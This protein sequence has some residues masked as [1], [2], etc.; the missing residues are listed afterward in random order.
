MSDDTSQQP[1]MQERLKVGATVAI[2][3]LLNA[4]AAFLL[5]LGID[6]VS[7]KLLHKSKILL[8][9]D[10]KLFSKASLGALGVVSAIS[11]GLGILGFATAHHKKPSAQP[12][13]GAAQ[14]G[15]ASRL[16]DQ[17]ISKAIGVDVN[18]R[19]RLEDQRV[20]PSAPQQSV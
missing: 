18:F 4:G 15:M 2:S 12:E 3:G 13:G 9:K 20:Q 14:A 19:Q 8:P 11:A 16:A 1:T 17:E 10:Y 6:A 7:E 5:I